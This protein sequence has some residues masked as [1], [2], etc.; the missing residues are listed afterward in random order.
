VSSFLW[1]RIAGSNRRSISECA[2][3]SS[4]D[5]S[6]EEIATDGLIR[7]KGVTKQPKRESGARPM[8]TD[9]I[10]NQLS[11]QGLGRRRIEAEFDAGMVT[12]DAGGLLL[13]ETAARTRMMEGIGA[14]FTDGRDPARVEH[15]VESLVAQ[16]IYGIALGYE[17]L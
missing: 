5:I 3:C 8:R 14:C 2:R 4:P 11:F 17:D 7:Q 16:R 13:R 12:S 6:P 9:C 10:P 1:A 15:T